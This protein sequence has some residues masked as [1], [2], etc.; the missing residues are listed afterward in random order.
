MRLLPIR[1]RLRSFLAR[2]WMRVCSFGHRLTRKPLI[3]RTESMIT[4]PDIEP[5]YLHPH[6]AANEA[7]TLHEGPLAIQGGAAGTGALVLRWLPSSGLQLEAD[8]SGIGHDTGPVKVEIAGS[9]AEVLV[10]SS[11]FGVNDGVS[12]TKVSGSVSTFEKGVRGPVKEIGFQV[13]NFQ[14]FLTRG[15]KAAP[16]FGF[17]PHVSDLRYGGWRVRLTVVREHREIFKSLDETGGYAFTHLGRLEREDGALFEIQDAEP[18]LDALRRFLSFARG[19]ACNFPVR[20]GAG[21][22]G[23]IVWEQWG[24]AVV[25][26]WKGR[27]NWFDEHHGNLLSEL[28]PAF[29]QI[30]ADPDLEPPLGLALHWY[31]TSNTRAGGM[32][33]AIIL[34]LTALDLLAALVVVDKAAA[35]GASKFDDLSA[36]VK[37]TK[38]LETMKVQNAIPAKYSHLAAF[39]AT[40]GWPTAAE[41]LAEIRH[42]YV[43]SN[44]KRRQIVLSAPNLATFEAWQLSLWY[45]ELALLYLLDHR[46]EY[47]N[48]ITAGWLGEV[49]KVPWV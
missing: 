10:S 25:D 4:G 14:D 17:P 41:T 23:S 13:V 3:G 15:P 39:A 21:P 7:V 29:A 22:D 32:E 19:A 2:M 34:G 46:G 30:V 28:F 42:G 49:E 37:L 6:A 20:W 44:K 35:M 38:L 31:R 43:H 33:G 18:V 47:R 45:Q 9:V 8:L 36:K 12:F 48:R 16:V 1:D 40:N 11:S 26:A 5:L 24:S 27:D